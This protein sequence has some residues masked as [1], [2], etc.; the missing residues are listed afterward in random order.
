MQKIDRVRIERQRPVKNALQ[1]PTDWYSLAERR[2]E[3][4]KQRLRR[5][6]YRINYVNYAINR[7]FTSFYYE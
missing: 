5:K 7:L 4:R 2:K 6:N 1:E 3:T